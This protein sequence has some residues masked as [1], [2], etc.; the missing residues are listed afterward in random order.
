MAKQSGLA[1]KLII[2]GFDVSGDIGG[3]TNAHGGPA[4]QDMTGI[5][6]SAHER[7]GTERNADMEY[8]AFFNNAAGQAHAVFSGLPR[9][10]VM[11]TYMAGQLQGSAAACM[12]AKQN[13]YDFKRTNAADL[14]IDIK[15]ASNGFGLEWGRL[16]SAGLRT[17]AG[18]TSPATGLDNTDVSTLFGWQ[19]YLQVT[20]LTGTNVIVTLQD[21]ADNSAFAN[22]A[23]GAFTSVTAAA[24]TQRLTGGATDTVRRYIRAITTGTFSSATFSLMFVRNYTAVT[25]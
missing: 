13:N 23:S 1:Q 3:I 8:T 14:T 4:F 15:M 2:G 19:A 17:D 18:A 22:L 6:K 24:T 7:V 5:D 16:I 10:D 11:N 9:T 25:F 21:S 20:A 12:I